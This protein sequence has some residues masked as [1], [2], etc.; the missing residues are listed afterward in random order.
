MNRLT[1]MCSPE[2]ATDAL[3]SDSS[4]QKIKMK[5]P[6]TKFRMGELFG[7]TKEEL[8]GFLKS[9]S[10]SVP[11]EATWETENGARVPK[12]VTTSITY[13]VI[14]ASAPNLNTN[15]YGYVGGD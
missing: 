5:P 13:Q 6:L 14:H 3:L 4:H 15:F 9:V 10:Y 2:Y 11:A 7:K 1:S 12:Y 8:L